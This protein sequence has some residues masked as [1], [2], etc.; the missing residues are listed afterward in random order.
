[1]VY[2]DVLLGHHMP[3]RRKALF[4]KHQSLIIG[5]VLW[6]AFI[7][8]VV[9]PHCKP[10]QLMVT[11]V[12]AVSP[13]HFLHVGFEICGHKVAAAPRKTHLL[14]IKYAVTKWLWQPECFSEGFYNM[15]FS[16]KKSMTPPCQS[17]KKYDPPHAGP[18]KSMTPPL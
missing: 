14:V 12:M 9:P 6:K 13:R 8:S 15:N 2:G 7:I 17:K 10:I 11:K 1:M 4:C 5:S 3:L 18:K 16:L